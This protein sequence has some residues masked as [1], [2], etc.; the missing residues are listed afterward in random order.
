LAAGKG[1]RFKSE[2]PK[3]VHRLL[4]KPMVFYPYRALLALDPIKVAVIV[5]HRAEVVKEELGN[6]PKVEFFYQENP[7][8]GTGDAVSKARPLLERYPD[9]ATVVLNGD[10]PLLRPETLKAGFERFLKENLDALIFT[11]ELEDPTGYGRIVRDGSGRVVAVVEEKDAT[12]EERRIKEVNGGFY[13][14]KTDL[15]LEVLKELKPSPATGEVYLTDAVKILAERGF[16]VD[17]YRAPFEELL[18]VNDRVQLAEA[19]KVLLRRKIESLQREGVTVRLPETVYVEWD[20]VV[21][22]DT[23]IEPHAV[24]RGNTSVGK[25]CVIGA[26]SVLENAKVGDG[27][28]ILPY[29]FVSDSEV[30]SGAVV[31]PFA[32]IRNGCV[33]GEGAEVGNFVEMKATAFGGGSKAKHLAYLGD[34]TVGEGVNVGAGVVFANYDGVEKHPTKV[35]D[36]AFIGSNSLIIAPCELGEWSFVAGGSVVNRSV[37][38]RALAVSRPE[39]KILE[40]KN[41]ILKKR[42]KSDKGSNP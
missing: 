39:L 24:L 11:A 30:K 40:N 33:V 37:P 26:G 2:R 5:G 25:N 20:A 7:K 35:G 42:K 22:R 31:G 19:E 16:K 14:F 32:R 1:T 21:G 28:R 17:T 15:L 18:G 13:V 34:A 27:V 38:P 9:S 41:P 23:E 3:V 4:G 29:S 8:G 6:Y 10:S 12:E 36:R